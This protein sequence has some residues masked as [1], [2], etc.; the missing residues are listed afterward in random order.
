MVNA[1]KESEKIKNTKTTTPNTKRK[2]CIVSTPKEFEKLNIEFKK[3]FVSIRLGSVNSAIKGK[4]E[5]TPI[6]SN[7]AII[8]IIISNISALFRSFNDNKYKIFL[9]ICMEIQIILVCLC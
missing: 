4:I 8:R 2:S 3:L 1:L 6:S 7:D 9:N 5:T